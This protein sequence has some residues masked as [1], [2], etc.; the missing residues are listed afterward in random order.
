MPPKKGKNKKKPEA[1]GAAPPGP[2]FGG[3]G[4]GAGG[5]DKFDKIVDIVVDPADDAKFRGWADTINGDL[6]IPND[7]GEADLYSKD[8]VAI[9]TERTDRKLDSGDI[10]RFIRANYASIVDQKVDDR[11]KMLICT[12]RLLA[13]TRGLALPDDEA[14]TH[15]CLYNH[16]K[17]MT[18]VEIDALPPNPGYGLWLDYADRNM[19][20]KCFTNI[21]CIVAYMFRSRG[22]HYTDDMAQRYETLTEKVR[23]IPKGLIQPGD[24]QYIATYA[25]HCI[26]PDTLDEFYLSSVDNARCANPLALRVGVPAAG[27]AFFFA[28]RASWNS[29]DLVLGDLA[30]KFAEKEHRLRQII[31]Y[32]RVNRW[33]G[34]INRKYYGAADLPWKESDFSD[35]AAIAFGIE[36]VE[37]LRSTMAKAASLQRVSNNAPLLRLIYHA[38]TTGMVQ[39]LESMEGSRMLAEGATRQIAGGEFAA[40]SVD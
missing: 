19:I 8:Y 13:Y 5:H 39:Y 1:K 33:A 9:C 3:G 12:L 26:F 21:V 7:S 28:L 18:D 40:A 10:E 22:H 38:R 25:L 16:A 36:S 27:T 20:S 4:L 23:N 11:R 30:E 35:M 24:W 37:D 14:K 2:G 32:L 29:N 31:A 6:Y 17:R 34:G 15:N